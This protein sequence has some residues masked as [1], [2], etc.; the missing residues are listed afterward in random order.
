MVKSQRRSDRGFFPEALYCSIQHRK[1]SSTFIWT[2]RNTPEALTWP[3]KLSEMTGGRRAVLVKLVITALS[4]YVCQVS[5]LRYPHN[6]Y[7]DTCHCCEGFHCDP[8]CIGA[9]PRVSDVC[10][11]HPCLR[12]CALSATCQ[13]TLVHTSY[14]K[15]CI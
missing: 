6:Q 9:T 8:S 15:N 14:H 7:N 3:R 2:C 1:P 5:L 12:N 10:H 13:Y 11:I 4:V